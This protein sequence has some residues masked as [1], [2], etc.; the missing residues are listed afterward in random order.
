MVDDYREVPLQLC[1]RFREKSVG[2]FIMGMKDWVVWER[3]SEEALIIWCGKVWF[4]IQTSGT[5]TGRV[6][7][8]GTNEQ[9]QHFSY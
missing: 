1:E 2:L 4:M 9:Q 3:L 6:S 7:G 8:W 5:V